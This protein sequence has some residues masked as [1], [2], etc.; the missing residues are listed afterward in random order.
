MLIVKFRSIHVE[1]FFE[2]YS[3]LSDI[4]NSNLNLRKIIPKSEM[5]KKIFKSLIERLRLKKRGKQ[6]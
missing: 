2:F 1:T 3:K 4:V 6:I 5:I